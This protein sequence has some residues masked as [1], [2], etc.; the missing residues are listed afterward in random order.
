VTDPPNDRPATLGQLILSFEQ[1]AAIR[2]PTPYIVDVA[3]GSRRLMLFGTEHSSD[4][5]NPMFDHLEAAFS[6]VRP[7]F[8]LH[9]GTPPAVEPQREIAIRR[10]GEAGLIRHLAARSGIDTAS[11][12]IPLPDEA[13][14][15]LHAFGQRDAL[16]FLV[17]R[18]LASF[19]RKTAR[20]D[21]DAYFGEFFELIAPA[22]NLSSIE[23]PMIET[24]HRRLL[25]HSL[26]PRE[27]TG[28]AT[29]PTRQEL[30]TQRMA[31]ISNQW[32]DEHMLHRLLDTVHAHGRVLATVGV[33]H[34]VM[35]EPALRVALGTPSTRAT[36][37][38]G[39]A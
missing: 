24:E 14:L 4:P 25:G 22:L 13:D 38:G 19:N 36:P 39:T 27:V 16:V 3:H 1:Y 7:A 28:R 5:G 31:R 18:Q 33:S 21:F 10:H 20:M 37:R 34:A 23:W 6:A 29:D 2:H 15:L 35:L 32:R 17:V 30:A 26:A 11:M 12:D 8:A 9:E